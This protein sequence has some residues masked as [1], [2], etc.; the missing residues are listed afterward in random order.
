[1]RE[2][3]NLAYDF[4]LFTPKKENI[5][6][7]DRVREH[8]PEQRKHPGSAPAKA[9]NLLAFLRTFTL[10]AFVVGILCMGLYTRG[11]ITEMKS[12]IEK[13]KSAIETLKSEET[14]LNMEIE[15]SLS[16]KNI[17]NEA[18]SMGMQKQE[19]AQTTYLVL[20]QA[21]EAEVLTADD[22]TLF[23]KLKALLIGN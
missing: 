7:L 15:A 12:E 1:M 8:Q 20:D 5:I 22:E 3:D 6:D 2:Q 9:V 16:V 4:D 18:A 14:R 19:K 11:Q 23:G 21:D 13:T 10:V 17:E